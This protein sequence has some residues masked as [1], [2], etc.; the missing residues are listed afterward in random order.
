MEW[1]TGRW[2]FYSPPAYD[3][4]SLEDLANDSCEDEQEIT[5]QLPVIQLLYDFVCNLLPKVGVHVKSL[6]L[7]CAGR[8]EIK[9]V[10]LKVTSSVIVC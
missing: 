9:Y 3:E 1:L 4:K 2:K 5:N 6:S 7:A 8:M 10:R